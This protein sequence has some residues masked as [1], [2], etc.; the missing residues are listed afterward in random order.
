MRVTWLADALRAEGV[1]VQEHPGWRTRGGDLG[2]VQGVICHHT[3]GPTRGNAPSLSTCV[4]G[5]PDLPGPLAQI[6]LARDGTAIV[7]AAGKA[8]HAG[9]G[10]WRGVTGNAHVLG[11][12]A[13][14]TGRGEPWGANQMEAYV[15]CCAAICRHEHLSAA[16]VCAHREWAPR[17]KPD[18]AGIE[19]AGFRARVQARLQGPVDRNAGRRYAGFKAGD[20]DAGIYAAGG[21]DNQVA[22][23]QILLGIPPTGRYTGP[24]VAQVVA[25]KDLADWRTLQ[26]ARDR[27]SAVDERFIQA[28]RGNR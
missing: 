27:T 23:L 5:R 24:A 6:V 13:E 10:G 25:L 16:A 4:N 22:E 26:G 2:Q 15:R 7:I 3:A 11:I 12:E 9:A 8:N 28:L 14:N 20:T 19:M 21:R 18:P 1:K 17:R